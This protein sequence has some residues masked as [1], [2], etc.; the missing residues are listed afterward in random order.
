MVP[1]PRA[2]RSRR[3]AALVAVGAMVAACGGSDD[4][5]DTSTESAAGEDDLVAL[6]AERLAADAGIP[7]ADATCLSEIIVADLPDLI[8]YED[9]EFVEPPDTPEIND[10]LLESLTAAGEACGLDR[11]GG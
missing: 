9:G 5:A 7:I 3:L 1:I 2:S 10:R 6:F 8:V 4:D 11:L